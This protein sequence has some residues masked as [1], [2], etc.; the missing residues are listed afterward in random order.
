MDAILRRSGPELTA[1]AGYYRATDRQAAATV[2][3]SLPAVLG[4][5]PT[6]LEYEFKAMVC[7]PASFA[8]PRQVNDRLTAPPEPENPPNALGFMD[9]LSPTSWAMKGFDVV[10]GFDP[11]GWVQERF[12]GDWEAVATMSPVLTNTGAALHNLTPSGSATRSSPRTSTKVSSPTGTG[13]SGGAN[14]RSATQHPDR[15][16]TYR[17]P[18]SE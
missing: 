18:S 9:Y 15:T 4:Q 8:D 17:Y 12:S 7:K 3:R 14:R 1:A 11:I 10:L 16:P 2:D 5:C 6:P 13:S